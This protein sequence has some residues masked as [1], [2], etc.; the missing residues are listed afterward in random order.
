MIVGL[1]WL[2]RYVEFDIGARELAVRLTNSLTETEVVEPPWKGVEGVVA[3]KVVTVEP[4]PDAD[5]LSVCVVD[6]G[7]GS[8]TVVCGAPNVRAGMTSVLAPPGSVIAGGRAMSEATIRGRRSHGMLASAMELGLE[9]ASEGI[10]ELGDGVEPG[11]DVRR[12]LGLDDELMDVDAQPNRPDC[13]GMIGIA[14]E[15]AAV[16]GGE[17]RYPTSDLAEEGP[18]AG[19]LAE[20]VIE[21]LVGCPRYIA[22]IVSDVTIGPSPM[23]LQTSLRSVGVRSISNIVDVTNFVML[24]FGHPIHAFDYDRLADHKIVVRRAADGE[25][26]TT[27]DD[28]ERKLDREHLLICDGREPVALAG[29]MG[30]ADSEVGDDTRNILLECAQFDPVV[31]RRGAARLALRTE[32]SQRFERG[33]DAAAMD[34]VAARAV[35]LMAELAGGRVAPGAVDAGVSPEGTRTV[36][37][38]VGRV[39][40]MLGADVGAE[41]SVEAL[42]RLGFEVEIERDGALT[43]GVPSHRPD[44]TTQA[45]L[46][47]EVLRGRGYDTVAP[48][49]PFQS[50]EVPADTGAAARDRVRDAVVGLGFVEVLTTSFVGR[51]VDELLTGGD[52]SRVIELE[53]PVNKEMPLLR[54]SI[55]P[56]LLDVIRRNK[57]VGE[58]D[59]RIFELG[60]VFWSE[61]GAPREKWMLAGAM[62]GRAERRSWDGGD[63]A[64]DFFD[65]KGVLEGMAEAL[66]VDTPDTACYDGPMLEAGASARLLLVG[67]DAGVLG[68][69]AGAVLDAREVSDPVFAFEIDLDVLCSLCGRVG[70]YEEAPR[71]PK[72]R[73]DMALVLDEGRPSGDIVAEVKGLDEP[74]LVDIE[75]FDIYRGEQ[76]APGKKSIGYGL[77]YMSREKTLTDEEVD[78]AHSRIVGHLVGTFGA[79]LRQ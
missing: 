27:L 53:N 5:K 18:R 54:T 1:N 28:I 41:E 2:K 60:K 57:N 48:E 79:S 56:Q 77:T 14:R 65:G 15:V 38:D 58:R 35:G 20:V 45:D 67:E 44:V 4:H 55:V 71:Y 23:W 12:M 72:V 73:R 63:R 75:V 9:E 7:A 17:L 30:G 51:G 39:S 47:E 19:E 42:S 36:R 66:D 8:S 46:I 16:T 11:A 40:S 25:V 32:A 43:V 49:L 76:L 64:V 31:V 61:G 68:M 37:L 74:L 24:E 13:L 29:V 52:G 50:L 69:V 6:W 21:D 33:V 3:A 62:T 10:L 26:M 34:L 70:V 22:R 78:V 59:L